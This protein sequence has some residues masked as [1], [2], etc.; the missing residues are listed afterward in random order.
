MADNKVV[1]EVRIGDKAFTLCPGDCIDLGD[2]GLIMFFGGD[3][4]EAV[5]AMQRCNQQAVCAAVEFARNNPG[6][7]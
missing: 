2:G 4:A 5:R 7:G 1:A 6:G 3:M